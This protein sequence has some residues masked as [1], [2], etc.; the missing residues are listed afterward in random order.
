MLGKFHV[1]C[2]GH[3]ME[4][5]MLSEIAIELFSEE[6]IEFFDDEVEHDN[7]NENVDRMNGLD[8]EMMNDVG[9]IKF[10]V[11]SFPGEKDLMVKAL[12]KEAL[13]MD[14]RIQFQQEEVQCR[15]A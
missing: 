4:L 15:H 7:E 6:M 12:I 1:T 11:K 10:C 2:T 8:P 14:L 3:P 9:V 13:N 5:D